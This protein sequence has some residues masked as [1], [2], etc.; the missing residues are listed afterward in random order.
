MIKRTKVQ[1]EFDRA[2]H[3]WAFSNRSMLQNMNKQL[4]EIAGRLE[5]NDP[6][7]QILKTIIQHEEKLT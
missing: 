1:E 5:P 6:R 4:K 2:K 7:H 3:G